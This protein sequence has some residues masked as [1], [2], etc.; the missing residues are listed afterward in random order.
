VGTPILSLVSHPKLGFFLRDLDRPDWGI[1]VH[2]QHLAHVLPRRVGE[3]LDDH[4]AV[5]ADVRS[6]QERLWSVTRRNLAAL[7]PEFGTVV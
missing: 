1:S 3:I 7:S 6:L 4:D 5:V 2:D